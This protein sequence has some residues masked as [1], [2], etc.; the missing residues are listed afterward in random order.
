MLDRIHIYDS[1]LSHSYLVFLKNVGRGGRRRMEYS[2]WD[3]VRT[4]NTA[5]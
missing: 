1:I 2:C 5:V 3:R 4:S